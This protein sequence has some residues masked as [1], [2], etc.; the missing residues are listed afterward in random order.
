MWRKL[1][2]VSHD[3]VRCVVSEIVSGKARALADIGNMG[4]SFEK[5]G[6]AASGDFATT[7]RDG[8]I[9]PWGTKLRARFARR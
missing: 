2:P 7:R 8:T 6:N 3:L 5:C 9:W 4:D 1:E